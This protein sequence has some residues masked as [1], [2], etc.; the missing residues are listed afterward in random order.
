VADLRGVASRARRW[1]EPI[2]RSSP[3]DPL[4]R[5]ALWLCEAI[6][7]PTA[8]G[9]PL[10]Y[11]RVAE[12]P[13]LTDVMGMTRRRLFSLAQSIALSDEWTC[14]DGVLDRDSWTRILGATALSYAR[15]G[16]SSMVA[17]LVRAAA[18]MRLRGTWLAAAQTYV[19]DQ[20]QPDGSFGL[21]LPEL[22][23]MRHTDVRA[24][25]ALRLTA[26]SLWAL[27]EVASQ[28]LPGR[29]ARTR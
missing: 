9:L 11:G 2:S 4:C 29:A 6:Q 18:R 25:V 19:L 24:R 26:E 21:V 3:D 17:A 28:K 12:L 16:D 27:A 22:V 8:A 15:T 23:V 20:Q 1:L 5:L 10:T 7:R 14:G 13:G